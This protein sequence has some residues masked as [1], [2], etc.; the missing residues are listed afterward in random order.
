MNVAGS[1]VL[2]ASPA[3]V[4]ELLDD[5][6]RLSA[7]LPNV[8][9]FGWT[10]GPAEGSFAVTIRPALALGEIPVRTVWQRLEGSDGALRYRIDG[11]TDEHRLAFDVVL[12]VSAADGAAGAGGA[13]GAGGGGAAEGAGAGR[14]AGAGGASVAWS[15]DCHVTG[16]LRTA[17][18]RVLVPIVDRQVRAVLSAAE[19]ALR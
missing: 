16:T 17:G 19:G 4:R 10:D 14:A 18:Q 12:R 8:D 2:D 3:M 11:R 7:V 1:A 13:G 15:L 5:P 6:E 9:A